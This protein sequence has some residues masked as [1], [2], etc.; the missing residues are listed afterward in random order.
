M[1]DLP[2]PETPVPG[3]TLADLRCVRHA[4]VDA[5]GVCYGRLEVQPLV[6]PA[7]ASARIDASGF[8]VVWSSPSTRC[9]DVARALIERESQRLELRVDPRLYELDFGDWEGLRWDA[10]PE[11]PR[12]AWMGDWKRAAP[13]NGEALPALEG[14]VRDWHDA[15][16][17]GR[18]HLLVAHA[19]V[20]R[21][22]W[23]IREGLTW[24]DA[25]SRPVPHL[26]SVDFGTNPEHRA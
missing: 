2:V 13:P 4:A 25:M 1:P 12:E 7:E 22:L 6:A 3:A 16:E 11:V 14:R 26:E 21:A 9:A 24:D 20:V 8:D 5:A 18:R 15:L 10:I 17:V 19:G 23:V